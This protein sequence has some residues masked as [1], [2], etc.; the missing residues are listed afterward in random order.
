MR[1]SSVFAVR[2]HR[3]EVWRSAVAVVALAAIATSLAWA[4]A[5][6]ASNAEHSIVVVASIAAALTAATIAAAVSLARV[7]AGVLSCRDDAWSFVAD[8]GASRTGRLRVAIDCGPFL[9]LRLE[10]SSHRSVWLPVQR[11]GLEHDWHALRCAVY[12]PPRNAAGPATA[13]P[14]SPE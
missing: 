10:P 12:S 9:L 14:S 3:F 5:T 11:R 1:D 7:P 4:F 2:L 6:A 13:S 8:G